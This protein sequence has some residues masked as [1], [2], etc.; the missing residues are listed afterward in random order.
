MGPDFVVPLVL[1]DPVSS[2]RSVRAVL[3]A[4][5]HGRPNMLCLANAQRT[6]DPKKW[7][8]GSRIVYAGFT[9]FYG[10]GLEDGHVPT[11]W[12][13][14][15]ISNAE[16]W[17]H[18]VSRWPL[19]PLVYNKSRKK[20]QKLFVD[21]PVWLLYIYIYMYTLHMCSQQISLYLSLCMHIHMF[22]NTHILI[23]HAIW[24][25]QSFLIPAAGLGVDV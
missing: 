6:V 10:L 12:L 20:T 21:L 22:I 25:L 3:T 15:Y 8:H 13:L 18:S 5:R 16:P 24:I 7:E 2:V 23:H 4:A 9:S 14:L 19:P 11:L 1:K 17:C